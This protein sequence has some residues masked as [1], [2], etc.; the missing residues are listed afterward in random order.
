MTSDLGRVIVTGISIAEIRNL[1][2]SDV[3]LEGVFP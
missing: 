3:S 2:L 1:K